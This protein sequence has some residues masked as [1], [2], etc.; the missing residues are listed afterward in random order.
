M[1]AEAMAESDLMRLVGLP[2]GLGLFGF[3]EPC[4]IGSTLLFIKTLERQDAGSMLAQVGV[5]MTIRA[6]FMGALGFVADV[7]RDL[8]VFR[9]DDVAG[10][11]PGYC[12]S[13]GHV[14]FRLHRRYAGGLDGFAPSRELGLD[15]CAEFL[16][17]AGDR[18]RAC[19]R[20]LLN[21][22]RIGDRL[23]GLGV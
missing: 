6:L 14:L 13:V 10:E 8:V 2:I 23:H 9:I 7:R 19:V 16:G 4:S 17:R 1:R 20:N 3:I 12:D 5:F 22:F 15:V 18:F 11:R 21:D